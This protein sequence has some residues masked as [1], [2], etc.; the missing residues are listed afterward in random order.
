MDP[1]ADATRER[2]FMGYND[3]DS[4]DLKE[5]LKAAEQSGDEAAIN[6]V[7]SIINERRRRRKRKH[8]LKRLFVVLCLVMVGG[9][10]AGVMANRL[11]YNYGPP[12]MAATTA[13]PET[14]TEAETLAIQVNEESS[15]ASFEVETGAFEEVLEMD[16]F[17]AL[18]ADGTLSAQEV[19]KRYARQ[20]DIK[21]EEYPSRIIRLLGNN[22]ETLEF[23]L[24]YPAKRKKKVQID[25]TEFQN[26]DRVPLLIQWDERWGYHKYGSAVMGLTGCGPTSLS[27]VALYLTKNPEYTPEWVA[28]FSAD[29]GYY[30][31]GS[32]SAWAL[33]DRGAKKLGMNV[34]EISISRSSIEDR[35]REGTPLIAVV[36]P[37]DFTDNG[38]FLVMTGVEDDKIRLNDPNS[39]IRSE[40]LWDFDELES[41]LRVVWALSPNEETLESLAAQEEENTEEDR[42]SEN[43][44]DGGE[45]ADP[46]DGGDTGENEDSGENGNTGENEESGEEGDTGEDENSVE[47]G[48]STEI[49]MEH[50]E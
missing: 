43:T 18:L 42:S 21:I 28:D 16:E 4:E 11:Y 48:D 34:K 49:G 14:S 22:P 12:S 5:L 37:G 15:T 3:R 1:A 47:D 26:L 41:Q 39:Y 13:V 30:V 50:E 10:I 45:E 31:K 32:G 35:L 9:V 33:V 19:V 7:Q 8:I 44:G 36:G 23:V 2:V 40:R 17:R 6:Q 29:N 46:E 38:H 27:M 24:N 25:R 20:N